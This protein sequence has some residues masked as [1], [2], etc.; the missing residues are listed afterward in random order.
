MFAKK[1]FYAFQIYLIYN[2]IHDTFLRFVKEDARSFGEAGGT[3]EHEGTPSS[4][5]RLSAISEQNIVCAKDC[6]M[7]DSETA[8][9]LIE[10]CPTS[11]ANA[12]EPEVQVDDIS[13]DARMLTNCFFAVFPRSLICNPSYVVFVF[14]CC[15][16][17]FYLMDSFILMPAMAE[18]A[19][20][21]KDVI[22]WLM[23]LAGVLELSSRVISGWLI[24]RWGQ[25]T[26]R[27]PGLNQYECSTM[28]IVL[29]VK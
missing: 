7:T 2:I 6:R 15:P 28:R 8:T 14:G 1:C 5:R 11:D 16:A 20:I 22:V 9:N 24:D 19:G 12:A 13:G 27:H 21:D 17:S 23:F 4:H 18:E 3:G 29:F 26:V 10:S 25:I